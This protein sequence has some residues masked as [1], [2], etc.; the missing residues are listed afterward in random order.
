MQHKNILI[1][2]L[3]KSEL[4]FNISLLLELIWHIYT[5]TYIYLCTYFDD[6]GSC[7]G[8]GALYDREPLT[9]CC[10]FD[11]YDLVLQSRHSLSNVPD[12]PL[13]DD[14]WSCRE[15]QKTSLW[16]RD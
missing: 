8:G 7:G 1:L 16:L 14:L 13:P 4:A 11:S 10:L 9:S 6:G 2:A 3:K 5:L 15:Q 12:K